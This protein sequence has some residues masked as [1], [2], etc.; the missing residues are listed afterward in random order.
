MVRASEKPVDLVC[1]G[2][3]SSSGCLYERREVDELDS[4]LKVLVAYDFSIFLG[5]PHRTED[6]LHNSY[7]YYRNGNY[8]ICDKINL[9]QPFNEHNVYRPGRQPGLVDTEFGRFGV[10][11]CYDIRFPGLFRTLKEAGADKIFVPAAFPRVRISEWRKLLVQRASENSVWVIGINSVGND[12]MNAFG[13]N[14]MVVSPKGNIMVQAGE[15]N[16]EVLEMELPL[17]A[18]NG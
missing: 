2:E 17:A 10:A 7:M 8:T 16:E 11:V 14:S 3:L 1:F 12:G 9:F 6:G 5:F 18:E 15:V 13:G 4:I